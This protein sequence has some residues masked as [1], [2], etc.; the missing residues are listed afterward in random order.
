MTTLAKIT[1]ALSEQN[2]IL[3]TQTDELNNIKNNL[4][5]YLEAEKG[6]K[7][8]ELEEKIK[9]R[10]EAGNKA[11]AAKG[12]AS[13]GKRTDGG[14]FLS[15]NFMLG[16]LGGLG[17]MSA[18]GLG[19]AAAGALTIGKIGVIA[20]LSEPISDF[21]TGF[22]TQMLE[23]TGLI[24]LD[25]ENMAKFQMNM[26][27]IV[28]GGV[29]G[30][31]FGKKG[32]IAGLVGGAFQKFILTKFDANNDEK[33]TSEIAGIEINWTSPY[34]APIIGM[35]LTT[36]A[37]VLIKAVARRMLLPAVATAIGAAAYKIFGGDPEK[38][39]ADADAR[40]QFNKADAE[41]RAQYRKY[42]DAQRVAARRAQF[43]LFRSADKTSMMNFAEWEAEQ[44]RLKAT[45]DAP[46][47]PVDP[48][49][50]NLEKIQNAVRTNTLP[51]RYTMTPTG[52]FLDTMEGNKF[53]SYSQIAAD[54][55][56][57]ARSSTS[58]GKKAAADASRIA[59]Y[60][61]MIERLGKIA[62]P[63]SAALDVYQLQRIITDENM[64]DEEKKKQIA[65]EVA[66]IG[67][68]LAFGALGAAMGSF[69]VPPFGTL[70]GG[71]LGAVLGSMGSEYL[72]ETLASWIM[73]KQVQEADL[74]TRLKMSD[75]KYYASRPDII[76]QDE[77]G[78]AMGFAN[79]AQVRAKSM[80]ELSTE[81]PQIYAKQYQAQRIVDES[82]MAAGLLPLYPDAWRG[83]DNNPFIAAPT[84]NQTIINQGDT[85]V[86]SSKGAKDEEEGGWF[87]WL[88]WK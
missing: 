32:M 25:D 72:G 73:G 15:N 6:V 17:A 48:A 71:V 14:G 62:G 3:N 77:T 70:A 21:I 27:D 29:I 33:I 85:V 80:L 41:S 2:G 51:S 75:A 57:A 44:A 45:A 87:S 65:G 4:S 26:S 38:A 82:R 13:S 24:E 63:L 50:T 67:G 39:R 84:T 28:Q 8:D 36:I 81:N 9:A 10:R 60:A 49:A 20:A 31:L 61:P 42:Q 12:A 52:K 55:D 37:G 19:A 68:S 86:Q 43:S 54:I 58:A 7:L 74:A 46:K 34:M 5:Q 83:M 88:P 76:G 30:L 22:A 66:G 79:S 59:K 11:R 53:A 16:S 56:A 69:A 18:A 47:L 40:R 35:A 23:N 1:D 64:T 78:V